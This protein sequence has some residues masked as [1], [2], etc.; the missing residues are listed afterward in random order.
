MAV[1][2]YKLIGEIKNGELSSRDIESYI[3]PGMAKEDRERLLIWKEELEFWEEYGEIYS[4]LEKTIPYHNLIKSIKKFIEPKENDVWL[5]VG[6]GP[7]SVSELICDKSNKKVRMIEAIDVVLKPAKEKIGKLNTCSTSL[8]VRLK[9][10]SITDVLPYPDNFFDGIGANLV[11]PY[12]IDFQGK[13]GKEAFEGVMREM[14]RIL[15]PGGHVV[16]STPKLGV[17]FIWVFIASIPDMLNIYEYIVHKDYTRILQGTRILKHALTI[18]KK[19]KEGVYTFLSEEELKSLLEKIG[20]VE[21]SWEK[22]FAQQAWV[23][24]AYKPI[25]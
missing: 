7:L 16:W 9:Y 1:G 5:D 14:F 18:Q 2:L 11:L 19:G 4:N 22:T 8:P 24:R 17:N 13:R 10:A 21:Q 15:K 20:F 25:V 12:V 23:N 3:K 6:C